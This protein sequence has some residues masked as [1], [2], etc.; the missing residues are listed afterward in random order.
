MMAPD[1]QLHDEAAPLLDWAALQGSFSPREALT[2]TGTALRD[3]LHVASLLSLLRAACTVQQED[4]YELWL[5]R[6][7]PRRQ[8]IAGIDSARLTGETPI[9]AA[10]LGQGPFAPDRL[11]AALEESADAAALEMLVIPLARAGDPAPGAPL[12]PA[13]RARMNGLQAAARNDAQLA[14]GFFGREAE[15][16]QMANW[17]QSPLLAAPARA[18]H[19]SGLPGIGKSYLLE[20]VIQTARLE[21]A[22]LL[23]RL[24]FDR[25]GL[26]ILD[27][28]GFFAEISRQLADA[29]P[30]RAAELQALRLQ[31][32]EE[33]ASTR[34]RGAARARP[35]A[36]L[37][38]M[39]AAVGDSGRLLLV[40][41]DTLEVL[42]S[43]GETHV[44]TLFDH[45]DLMLR[46]GLAPMA[47]ISA[48]RG[49]ALDPAPE[50]RAGRLHLAGLEDAAA[51]E[52][53][54][55]NNVPK[56]HW[57][58]VLAVAGG[59]PLLLR[60]AAKARD[61]GS[62]D[63]PADTPAPGG[64]AIAGYLYRAILSRVPDTLRRI[65][66]E[67]LVLARINVDSL[68]EV[69]APALDLTLTEFEARSLLEE[70]ATHHWLVQEVGGWLCHRA[71][72]RRAFLPLIYAD[73]GPETEAINRAAALWFAER[74]PAA[75]LYHRLQLTRYG[76]PLPA[77][78]PEALDGVT[79]DTLA[80]LPLA[81]RDAVRQA[82]GLRSDF[83]RAGSEE[84]AEPTAGDVPGEDVSLFK[85]AP[86]DS[87]DEPF[88][89]PIEDTFGTP[90]ILPPGA[91]AQD[92]MPVEAPGPR[93]FYDPGTRR[94][95]SVTARRPAPPG[96]P[97]ARAVRDLS[98]MLLEGAQR[99][100]GYIL[101]KG[102][103]GSFTAGSEAGLT[104]LTYLWL[105]GHWGTARRLFEA[106]TQEEILALLPPKDPERLL[107]GRVLLEMLAEFRPTALQD[108]L[109]VPD[110]LFPLLDLFVQTQRQGLAGG[111][112]DL[113]LLTALPEDISPPS[114]LLRSAGLITDHLAVLPFGID[115]AEARAMAEREVTSLVSGRTALPASP[116]ASAA[117][118]ALD[119]MPLNPYRSP[120]VERVLSTGGEAVKSWL[121]RIPMEA[122]AIA[123]ALQT[124]YRVDA[125]PTSTGW[126]E[127]Y[128]D[129]IDL[130][131]ALGLTA[132]WSNG[133]ALHHA[134]PDLPL[135]AAAAERW[136]RTVAGRWSHGRK[137]KGWTGP[138]V[139]HVSHALFDRLLGET[140]PIASAR[141]ALLF[142]D[143]SPD[144]ATPPAELLR[145][146]GPRSDRAL[147]ARGSAV[148]PAAAGL[149][150]LRGF[151]GAGVPGDQAAALAVLTAH[152]T[153]L[154]RIIS[155]DA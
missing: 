71:D 65:A 4:G 56:A 57:P 92:L 50:R 1:D 49:D 22:P 58:E 53:L 131:G 135:I 148:E 37:S 106:L 66:N 122:P 108:H 110:R 76:D 80:E 9:E 143:R 62:L 128:G 155:P 107:T 153:D 11:Q 43:R 19:V 111:A 90:V 7:R 6:P 52:L 67:G 141:N 60:L 15:L 132:E 28:H 104:A 88:L 48:G 151:L 121:E 51:E 152:D 39:G 87:I 89:M 98:M 41:L 94:I 105:S 63:L 130:L 3:P 69:V 97:D 119:L 68:R 83:G 40:V 33:A 96:T 42:R 12:L 64:I 117:E 136:R 134:V 91:Q 59:N 61:G 27:L 118:R 127:A 70:L 145:R 77:L 18:L 2:A 147:K 16:A 14:S 75:A 32:A 74:D 93:F 29:L 115:A 82:M 35:E 114:E 142:W 20:K 8:Q 81:V 137:P 112:L 10:L 138:P 26:D 17:L 54:A 100:A 120:L 45:L 144:E 72:V 95:L 5:M 44:L 25:G 99:E 126:S 47:V 31:S 103:E 85:S 24:D 124:R 73:R 38:G 102:F 133:F 36:L 46:Y 23:V 140:D 116:A 30:D 79:E 78:P 101:D 149:R 146:H 34:G 129:H 125:P 139:D 21:L 55:E 113:L 154:R 86:P 123:E 84:T 13:L 150:A 109:A